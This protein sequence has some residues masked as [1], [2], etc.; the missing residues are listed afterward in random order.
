MTTDGAANERLGASQLVGEG[1]DHHCD[2][3]HIQ[4]AIEDALGQ[5]SSVEACASHR[6]VVRKAHSLVI[7]INGQ[8]FAAS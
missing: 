4:L 6:A 1:G 8:A 3:H 2:A 7:L 5:N